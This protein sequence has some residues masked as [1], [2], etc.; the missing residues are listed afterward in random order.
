MRKHGLGPTSPI[1][2]ILH[3]K[4]VTDWLVNLLPSF[5]MIQK[6]SKRGARRGTGKRSTLRRNETSMPVVPSI[7]LKG[8]IFFG[9]PS[10]LLTRLRYVDTYTLSSTSGTI[11][12][13]V[14][15][16]NDIYQ[17]SHT[18][19]THQ[20]LYH[21]TYASLYN[22]WAVVSTK[23]TVQFQSFSTTTSMSVGIVNEDD[24]TSSSTP[25]TLMEQNAGKHTLLPPL[26]GSLSN[27]TMTY[28]W[29]AK[30]YFSID[31]YTSENY[32]SDFGSAPTQLATLL[33]WSVPA[34]GSSTA[35]VQVQVT[36]EYTVL[37]AELQTPTQS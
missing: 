5:K 15:G 31:P 24:N 34:D 13:Q 21:D 23:V 18:G 9:F 10:T 20:P 26:A 16:L 35:S 8:K 11:A 33:V 36:M 1:W 6:T 25:D 22:K 3:L 12:K 2:C 27:R 37:F 14:M 17:P 28:N 32:K 19:G 4:I 29:D 30:R 7:A